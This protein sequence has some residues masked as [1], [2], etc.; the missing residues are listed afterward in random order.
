MYACM[1]VRRVLFSA[2]R[3]RTYTR[4]HTHTHAHTHARTHASIYITGKVEIRHT[5]FPSAGGAHKAT[6]ITGLYYLCITVSHG[7]MYYCIKSI[8]VLLY[9]KAIY[10]TVS[11]GY[12]YYRITKLYVL[13]YHKTICIIVSQGCMYYCIT[14]P[15]LLLC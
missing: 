7:Y 9:H 2:S 13:L 1:C 12:M 4:T 15:Y 8:Y 10:I 11:Q 14:R 5:V 6:C 3:A